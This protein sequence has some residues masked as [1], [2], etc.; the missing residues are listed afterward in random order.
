MAQAPGRCAPAALTPLP[1][2]ERDPAN[3]QQSMLH[4]QIRASHEVA[5]LGSGTPR[6]RY[7]HY[8]AIPS[9]SSRLN[10]STATATAIAVVVLHRRLQ[11]NLHHQKHHALHLLTDFGSCPPQQPRYL[12]N[13]HRIVISSTGQPQHRDAL[14]VAQSVQQL[15]SPVDVSRIPLRPSTVAFDFPTTLF[16]DPKLTRH[17]PTI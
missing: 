8:L 5:T 14:Y 13:L 15:L 3:Q 10:S 11:S 4:L 6:Q 1:L 17:R 12:R 7:I 16:V 2:S 9:I